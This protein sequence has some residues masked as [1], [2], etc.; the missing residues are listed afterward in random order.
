MKIYYSV[1][2]CEKIINFYCNL[3]SV[4]NLLKLSLNTFVSLYYMNLF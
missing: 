1:E 4:K 3:I 2:I